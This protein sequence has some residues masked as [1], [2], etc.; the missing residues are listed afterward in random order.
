MAKRKNKFC[1]IETKIQS[2]FDYCDELN[3]TG[4]DIVKPYTLSGLLSFISVTRDEFARLLKM[5]K[6]QGILNA[7][8]AKI[9]A[10]IEENSLTGGLSINASANSLKYNFG[11]GEHK[12]EQKNEDEARD[13]LITIGDDAKDYAK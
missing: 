1:D 13:I 7:A 9:E 4:N 11:W 12:T 8:L 10:Y 5:R 3:S 2:Y 6:Y